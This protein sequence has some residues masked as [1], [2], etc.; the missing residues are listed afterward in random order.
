MVWYC[1][2]IIYIYSVVI[3]MYW[4]WMKQQ[5]KHISQWYNLLE[6]K[7]DPMAVSEANDLNWNLPN[8]LA[9]LRAHFSVLRSKQ[10]PLDGVIDLMFILY[11]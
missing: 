4:K 9:D 2:Y 8:T 11:E 1:A 3:Y 6:A 7:A 5:T 10:T